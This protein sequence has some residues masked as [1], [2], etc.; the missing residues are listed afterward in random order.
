MAKEEKKSILEDALTDYKQ[1]QEAAKASA[2]KKLADEFPD[3]FNDLLK[4]E[5]DKNNNKS[6]KEPYKKVNDEES[7]QLDESEEKNTQ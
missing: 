4:E 7:N 2:A 6:E 3:K 5:I 1:I